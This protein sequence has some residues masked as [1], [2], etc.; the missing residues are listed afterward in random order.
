M[1]LRLFL[2][3][4]VAF[5]FS[6]CLKV[7]EESMTDIAWSTYIEHLVHDMYTKGKK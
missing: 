4:H 3:A 6:F 5:V 2:H 7:K 1:R